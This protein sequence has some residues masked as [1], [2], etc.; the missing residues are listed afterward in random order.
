M[1]KLNEKI[2]GVFGSISSYSGKPTD[3]QLDRIN[4]LD[5]ELKNAK[6][7]SEEIYR[8]DLSKVNT[9]LV[10]VKMKKFEL[11]TREQFDK[12]DEKK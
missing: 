11:M 12:S 5:F 4:S 3:S 10:K 8:K 2:S 9:L 1:W 7:N 6:E